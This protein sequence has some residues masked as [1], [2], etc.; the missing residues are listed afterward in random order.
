MI[1]ESSF[2]KH[3]SQ[4]EYCFRK[5]VFNKKGLKVFSQT[6]GLHSNLA[7]K[8]RKESI[9]KVNTHGLINHETLEGRLVLSEHLSN[10]ALVVSFGMEAKGKEKHPHHSIRALVKI[11]QIQKS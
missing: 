6:K 4:L 10:Y 3:L 7:Q 1:P 11:W 9:I 2:H 8:I 5:K